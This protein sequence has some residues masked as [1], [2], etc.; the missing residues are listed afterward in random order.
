MEDGVIVARD[1]R[2]WIERKHDD[3]RLIREPWVKD[4]PAGRRIM[5][6]RLAQLRAAKGQAT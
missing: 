2:L 1:G 4:V 6:R 3:G 5:E